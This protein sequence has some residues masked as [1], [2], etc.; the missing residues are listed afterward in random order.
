MYIN[1]EL[2]KE[3]AKY[4][5]KKEI[6]GVVGARQSGKTTLI[7]NILDNLSK[8]NKKIAKISFDNIKDLQ[9]F[10]NDIDSFIE[11][12]VK[13][14]DYL[15]IDEVQYSKESGKKLK[16]IFDNFKIKLFISGS[17]AAEISIQSLKYLVGRI[18]IFT[19]YPFSFK[20]FLKTKNTKLIKIYEVG[21]YKEEIL[22]QLNKYLQEYILFGGYP[23]VVLTK[24]FKEKEV[25]L[26]NLYNTYLLKEIK[27]I[28]ELSNDYRLIN[29][30]KALSLQIGNIIN[31]NELSSLSGFTYKELKNYLNILDKT[32]ICQQLNPFYTNKR[33]E[34]VKS[35][36]IYFFDLGFRNI[37]IDNFSI[38]RS[39]LGSMYENFIFCEL[40]KNNYLPKYWHTKSGA[41]VDFILEKNA[42]LIP[43][44]VKT[45]LSDFKVTKSFT[46]F[47]DK[48]NSKKGFITSLSFEGTKN[49]KNSNIK[50]L[51]FTKLI[52]TFDKMF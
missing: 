10:E 48:Y 5:S 13:D 46:S 44:E 27:E 11:I 23:S 14:N 34:L 24:K 35:P 26:R 42:K 8:T 22:S 18:L 3:I 33:V 28:L 50:Y 47:L 51:P 45:T 19:L 30:I 12:Y 41:E 43:I 39:D 1:R 6:I 7:N 16:Y 31:Y 36:K 37:C 40:I 25:I 29:L 21:K 15:F 20:E 49:I 38:D 4:I 2:E 9:L 52:N 32:F 17:S